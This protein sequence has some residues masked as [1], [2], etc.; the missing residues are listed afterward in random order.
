M[1]I[2]SLSPSP[3]LLHFVSILAIQLL[4]ALQDTAQL[5][6]V[7]EC[8]C[9]GVEHRNMLHYLRT[10]VRC[11]LG[12]QLQPMRHAVG[13]DEAR[14]AALESITQFK[15]IQDGELDTELTRR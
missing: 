9:K 8:L 12:Q 5:G 13:G 7:F 2:F 1:L 3:N 6:G 14:D 11:L 4:A 15:Q 10:Q